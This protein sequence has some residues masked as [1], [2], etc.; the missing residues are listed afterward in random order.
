MLLVAA[1]S[2][3]LAL[4][5]CASPPVST[6][7][8]AGPGAP[9]DFTGRFALPSCGE[10]GVGNGIPLPP[11]AIECFR[12]AVEGDGAELIITM[13]TTEG[14]PIVH[15][16]RTGPGVE[17]IEIFIDGTADR[18][19]SGGW[20]YAACDGEQAITDETICGIG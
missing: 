7:N 4:S 16:F 13:A 2:I 3:A 19:G 18:F 1:T 20:D 12:K 17:G 5:G 8:P 9:D 15:Y 6:L 14:D 11:E 10:Y